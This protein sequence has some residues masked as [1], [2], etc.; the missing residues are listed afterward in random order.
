M[1]NDIANQIC[2]AVDLLIG[3]RVSSLQ[4]DKTVRATIL[5]VED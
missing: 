3:K 1:A 4:F 5:S 2:D